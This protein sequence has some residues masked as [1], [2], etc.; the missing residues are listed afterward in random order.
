MRDGRGVG[1]YRSWGFCMSREEAIETMKR[2]LDDEAG[3]YTHAV[4]ERHSDGIYALADQTQW[5]EW[6]I[7]GWN[8]IEK[9]EWAK[10]V[11]NWGM[12]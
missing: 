7:S 6:I 12:G 2:T 3:Y 10:Q 11:I 8:E 9:P 1:P 5:F 4:I